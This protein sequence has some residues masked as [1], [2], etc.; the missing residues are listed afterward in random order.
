MNDR[1]GTRTDDAGDLRGR[2]EEAAPVI[3]VDPE[4]V[5]RRARR[6]R[7][8]T[9]AVA[10]VGAA[11]AVLAVVLLVRPGEPWTGPPA[12]APPP[13]EPGR[14][15]SLA[16]LPRTVAPGDVVTA[17]LVANHP[18]DL[19]FGVEADVE[20]WDGRA[21]RRAG[22]TGLCLAEWSCVSTVTDR[23]EG[24]ESIGLGAAPGSPGPATLLSTE[25]LADGWYR[26]VQHAALRKGV[27]TGVF[28]VR[29]DAAPAPPLPDPN[30]LRLV[31]EPPLVPPEGGLAAVITWVPA[32]DDGSLTAEEIEAVDR[33]F[34]PAV[35]VQRWDGDGWLDV[36]SVPTRERDDELGVEWGS[37]VTL[38][39]LD[40]GAYRLVR[41]RADGTDAWGVLFVVPGAPALPLA[42]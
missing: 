18:N 42:P 8:V 19:T 5:A 29:R 35:L 20:R 25:G 26:L 34:D 10:A 16:V 41:T 36:V 30:G 13:A 23:L 28:E 39:R 12:D 22:V 2:F 4:P 32:G 15:V 21:W 17:V 31:V 7:A 27:A 40:E 37:P 14:A 6:R 24:S 1:R 11:A 9:R 38:P 33:S 3:L